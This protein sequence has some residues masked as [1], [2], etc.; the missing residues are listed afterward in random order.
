M[1]VS[2]NL[3]LMSESDSSMVLIRSIRQY[4]MLVTVWGKQ[5]SWVNVLDSNPIH[6]LNWQNSQVSG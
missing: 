3:A 4:T 2:M 5:Q 6:H 1:G